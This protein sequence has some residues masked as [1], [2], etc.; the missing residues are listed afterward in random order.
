MDDLSSEP[1]AVCPDP[2]TKLSIAKTPP[3]LVGRLESLGVWWSNPG[4][5]WISFSYNSS[6]KHLSTLQLMG[7]YTEI[8]NYITMMTRVLTRWAAEDRS[9]SC[10][11]WSRIQDMLISSTCRLPFADQVRAAAGRAQSPQV[12]VRVARPL[13]AW[14]TSRPP[15]LGNTVKKWDPEGQTVRPLSSAHTFTNKCCRFVEVR[16]C[17]STSH[18]LFCSFL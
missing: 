11:Q 1:S 14:L 3:P 12:S 17:A 16:P 13:T 7:S 8:R 4:N 5:S 6:L 18:R 9:P 10:G 2:P 15:C